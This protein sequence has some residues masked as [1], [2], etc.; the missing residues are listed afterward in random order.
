M[1]TKNPQRPKLGC[2]PSDALPSCKQKKKVLS[3]LVAALMRKRILT[4][5]E[6][7][8]M[9]VKLSTNQNFL[10]GGTT[11]GGLVRRHRARAAVCWTVFRS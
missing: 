9:L 4:D 1:S 2:F 5:A 6:G 7:R 8:A 10:Y 3:E 11:Q